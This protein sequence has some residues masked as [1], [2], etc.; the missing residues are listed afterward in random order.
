MSTATMKPAPMPSVHRR[1]LLTWMAVYPAITVAQLLI[2]PHV[3][4]WPVAGRTLLVTAV[5]VPCSVYFSVPFL[6]RLAR[7]RQSSPVAGS[8]SGSSTAHRFNS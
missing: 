3:A 7:R 5:A 4:H 6:M 2:G 1:A 8:T